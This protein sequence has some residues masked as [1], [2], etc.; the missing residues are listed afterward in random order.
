[1]NRNHNFHSLCRCTRNQFVQTFQRALSI[2]PSIR[3]HLLPLTHTHT[4]SPKHKTQHPFFLQYLA[5]TLHKHMTK[6]KRGPLVITMC[7]AI[8]DC[9]PEFH[10]PLIQV[11]GD[12]SILDLLRPLNRREPCQGETKRVAIACTV[13]YGAGF[14]HSTCFSPTLCQHCLSDSNSVSV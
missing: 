1:M 6:I 5:D 2:G 11:R 10:C 14:H 9:K 12:R 4:Q 13:P 8:G 3:T 7:R